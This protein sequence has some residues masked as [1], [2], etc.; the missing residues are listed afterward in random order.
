M[1]ATVDRYLRALD[2]M[3]TFRGLLQ[4]DTCF[5]FAA[6]GLARVELPDPARAIREAAAEIAA[7]QLTS[8]PF[9]YVAAALLLG[10]KRDAALLS[11]WANEARNA[12]LAAD[13]AGWEKGGT[14]ASLVFA[15]ALG[16]E[17]PGN[18]TA[19]M[20]ELMDLWKRDHPWLTG[21]EDLPFA[22]LHVLAG[23]SPTEVSRRTEAA[24]NRLRSLGYWPLNDLQRAT[25]LLAFADPAVTLPR[26]ERLLGAFHDHALETPKYRPEEAAL[27]ALI[28]APA[29]DL[30]HDTVAAF[31]ELRAAKPAP[32]EFEALSIA[33]LLVSD[34]RLGPLQGAA[35]ALTLL[36]CHGPSGPA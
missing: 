29:K 19:R 21:A 7:A 30:A 20:K 14:L 4:S 26:F 12:F 16:P 27:L 25:H 8:A 34:G 3:L 18:R 31:R 9:T 11:A 13:L 1:T 28:D 33:A 24:W 23:T 5:R 10:R 36:W 35:D 15:M 32:S 22:A 6:L 2:T 17:P